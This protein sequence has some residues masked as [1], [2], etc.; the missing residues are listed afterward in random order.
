MSAPLRPPLD[1][2]DLRGFLR[3]CTDE[4]MDEVLKEINTLQLEVAYRIHNLT[5]EQRESA[6]WKREATAWKEEA[7]R[8]QK[9]INLLQETSS[10]YKKQM[11]HARQ[12]GVI[13]KQEV[14]RLKQELDRIKK[15]GTVLS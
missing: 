3:T 9:E 7:V 14:I 4:E 2:D 8:M 1:L 11:D 13:G 12:L 15:A 5:L 6:M 10:Y